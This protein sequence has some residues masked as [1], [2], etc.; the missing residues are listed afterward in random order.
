LRQDFV[1]ISGKKVTLLSFHYVAVYFINDREGGNIMNTDELYDEI[2][3]AGLAEVK[4]IAARIVQSSELAE[5]NFGELEFL[6]RRLMLDLAAKMLKPVLERLN[7]G[8]KGNTIR[9]R[10]GRTA[11]FKGRREAWL[12]TIMG[13]LRL[14]KAYYYCSGCG[15]GFSP[16]EEMMRLEAGRTVALRRLIS[17]AGV[18]DAFERGARLLEEMAGIKVSDNTVERVAE[19]AG[20]EVMAREEREDDSLL[21]EVW[22][23]EP[24][25]PSK[26]EESAQRMYVTVDGTTAPMRGYWREFKVGAIYPEAGE[27]KRYYASLD[28]GSDFMLEMRRQAIRKGL[29][30]VKEVIALADGQPWIWKE[31]E[32]NFPMAVQVLDFW[33]LM[34]HVWALAR[35][36]WGEDSRQAKRW[37]ESVRGQ[38]KDKGGGAVLK[39]IKRLK[40]RRKKKTEREEIDSLIKYLTDNLSRVDYPGYI[41]RGYDIGSGPVEAACKTVIGRRLKGS[42]MRW[43]EVGAEKIAR[44]RA[45]RLSG[46]WDNFWGFTVNAA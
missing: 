5:Q 2:I 28:R 4:R 32:I 39:R 46:L 14:E 7:G 19:Q 15:R 6:L 27:Q 36:L 31:F 22:P 43:T 35:T 11:R 17:L 18:E 40:R 30:G 3:A 23:K 24:E 12:D 10:C 26:A 25:A 44:L 38:L 34:E 13:P 21:G 8:Y 9:C 37:A 20:Q 41:E 16:L 45:I 42:G 33:H 1:E 29:G